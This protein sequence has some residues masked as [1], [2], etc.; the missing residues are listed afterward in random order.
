VKRKLR[1]GKVSGMTKIRALHMVSAAGRV[2]SERSEI[3]RTKDAIG[4]A[5]RRQTMAF[6]RTT[7]AR[8]TR[9]TKPQLLS[10]LCLS[11]RN[12]DLELDGAT[13]PRRK[14]PPPP[15]RRRL[16]PPTPPRETTPIIYC[17]KPPSPSPSSLLYPTTPEGKTGGSK[18][19]LC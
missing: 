8:A 4:A 18:R 13:R 7:T 9:R 17:G 12:L 3:N 2:R 19:I 15:R 16:R 6:G 11:H 5:G 14:R 10:C 1:P